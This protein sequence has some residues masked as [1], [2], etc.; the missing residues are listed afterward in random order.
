MLSMTGLI[1]YNYNLYSV[2]R[3]FP[4]MDLAYLLN[5][6]L[7]NGFFKNIWPN[8]LKILWGKRPCFFPLRQC[9]LFN[10]YL[11]EFIFHIN[12][13]IRKKMSW[14]VFYL[15]YSIIW[16]LVNFVYSELNLE[17]A[18]NSGCNDKINA[19]DLEN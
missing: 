10:S 17:N 3:V 16:F 8:R 18:V 19:L 13:P 4:N 1:P 14:T 12:F 9:L 15:C 6:F 7:A 5:H 2:C 11:I